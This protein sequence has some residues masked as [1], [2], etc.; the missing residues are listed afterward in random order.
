MTSRTHDAFAFAALT[1][2]AV[3]YPP[4]SLNLATAIVSL[5]GCEIGSLLPDVD[6]ASNRLWDLL[7]GGNMIGKMCKGI[8]IAHRTIS[9]SLIGTFLLY[10]LLWLVLSVL[11]NENSIGIQT[12]VNSVMIGFLSHLLLDSFTEAGLPLFFPF[13]FKVGFPPLRSWRIKTGKGF[14]KFVVFPSIIVYLVWF[15]SNHQA[16]IIEILKLVTN[17]YFGS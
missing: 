15:A 1:T 7:P 5:I 6:Q 11:L 2:I 3:Y 17:K 16:K 14:E 9:H 13:T 12:V 10:K 8:F 4:G